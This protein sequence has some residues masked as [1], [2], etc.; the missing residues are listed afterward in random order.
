MFAELT[1]K[2]L[3]LVSELV[4]QTKVVALL[5][6]PNNPNADHIIGDVR[7]AAREK[8][9]RL[10]VLKAGSESEIDRAF[11]TLVQQHAGSLLVGN[12]P[13]FLSRCDQLVALTSR[14]AVPTIYDSREYALF[15]SS[16]P[17]RQS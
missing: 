16:C 7:E 12:D 11:A 9:L 5:V 1:A 4:P 15:H 2:R 17:T 13:F 10:H 8:G 6:N 3:E 14:H